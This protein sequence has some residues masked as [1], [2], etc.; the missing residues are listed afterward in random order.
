MPA[1][2]RLALGLRRIPSYSCPAMGWRRWH[3]AAAFCPP[4][5]RFLPKSES[6]RVRA[7]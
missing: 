6:K 2:S 3:G 4:A 1:P 7:T 5:S